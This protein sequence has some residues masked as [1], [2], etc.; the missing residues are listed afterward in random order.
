M[1]FVTSKKSN[2]RKDPTRL[3]ESDVN[4]IFKTFAENYDPNDA[5]K[6]NIAFFDIE[7]DFNK[8]MDLLNRNDPFNL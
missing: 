5:P 8:E 1:L 4:V 6:L 7:T 3:Y 2:Q